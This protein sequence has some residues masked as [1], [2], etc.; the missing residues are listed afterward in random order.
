MSEAV[1][2]ACAAAIGA[3]VLTVLGM[4][5]YVVAHFVIKYW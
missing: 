5:L 1:K 4:A 2:A 3:A